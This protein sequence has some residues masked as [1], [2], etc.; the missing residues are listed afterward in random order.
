VGL[1]C[2][3]WT[4][5]SMSSLP[6]P[7]GPGLALR[8]QENSRRYFRFLRAWWML[9]R[10][11]AFSRMA[12]RIRRAGRRKRAHQPATRRSEKHRLG[13]RCRERLRIKELLLNQN[14]LGDHRTDAARPEES[15]NR[16]HDVHE[17][18]DEIA[19]S[20]SLQERLTPVIVS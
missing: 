5:A 8:W 11:E 13:D 19:H 18:D 12:E 16:N 20:V 1:R 9:K 14:G 15:G 7:F 17:K 10:V 4:T 2:F 6:G 3:L